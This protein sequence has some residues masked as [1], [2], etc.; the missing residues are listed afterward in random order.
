M[1]IITTHLK[2]VRPFIVNYCFNKLLVGVLL[3]F[4]LKYY[5]IF[6]QV[7]R[8]KNKIYEL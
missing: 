4:N 2:R 3:F 7:D 8:R 6:Q 5:I 1:S